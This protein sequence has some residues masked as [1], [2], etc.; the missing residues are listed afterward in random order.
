MKYYNRVFLPGFIF[1][2]L[3]INVF[4]QHVII[5]SNKIRYEND[6]VILVVNDVYRGNIQWEVSKDKSN[7]TTITGQT[8]NTLHLHID[9]SAYYR[10]VIIEGTCDSIYSDTALVAELYDERDNRVYDVV[11]IGMKWWMAENLDYYTDNGTWYYD[12]DSISNYVYGRLYN[13]HVTSG[14]CPEGWHLPK[15]DEWKVLESELGMD[16]FVVDNTGW[17]GTDEGDKLKK[18]GSSGFDVLFGGFRNANGNYEYINSSGTFWTSS[19]A[20]AETAWYRGFGASEANIHRDDFEKNYGFSV[21]CVRNSTPVIE[22]QILTDSITKSSAVI[23]ANVIYDGGDI[24]LLRGL[25]WGTSY[26]PD[27]SDNII[28]AGSGLGVF[29]SKITGLT[30]NNTYYVR[31]F[32]VNSVD[33]AYSENIEFISVGKPILT[34]EAVINITT[35]SAESGGIVTDDGGISIISRGVCWSTLPNPSINDNITVDGSG[36]GS[37]TSSITGLDPNTTYYLKAYAINGM[38]SAYGDERIFIT[39]PVSQIDS[40]IDSRD[41][42]DYKIVKIG[43]QWWFGTNLNYEI[44]NSW[45]YNNNIA[46]C[47]TFGRLYTWDAALNSCPYGWHLP[48]DEEWKILERYLGMDSLDA[49]NINWRGTDQAKQ[50]KEGS[51]IGFNLKLG[52]FREEN[53]DFIYI[54]SSGTFWASEEASAQTAW[55]RGFGLLEENIHRY[56]YD[57][58]I[59]FSI[60]CL[61]TK[62]PEVITD[63]AYNIT[64]TSVIIDA[65]VISDGG[66]NVTERG[67]CY[68][69]STEPTIFD[70]KYTEGSGIGPFTISL[71]GL[72]TNTTYYLRAYAINNTDTAYSNEISFITITKPVV[73]TLLATSITKTSAI[74][75]GNVTDNGGSSIIERGVCYGTN[76]DPSYFDNR[77]LIGIGTG[78]FTS[79]LTGLNSNKTYYLK[80]YAINAKDTAYGNEISFKTLSV[81]PI[82]SMVDYRDSREYSTIK[83]GEQWWMAEN[84]HYSIANS[85]CYENNTIICDTFGRLYTWEAA[86]NS[87]PVEWHLPSDEEWKIMEMELGMT[88][89]SANSEGWRGT[90][91]GTQLKFEGSSGFDV[92]LGGFR[93][94]NGNYEYIYSSGTFWTSS[95]EST[96]TAW[97][98][99]FGAPETNIHRDDFEKNYSFSVRCMKDTLPIVI[100][101]SI[102]SITDSTAISGG[103]ITYDGGASVTARGVCWSTLHDPTIADDTTNNGDDIGTFISALTDLLPNTDYYVRAYA[104]NSSG[105][106]YG[107]EVEFTTEIGIPRLNTSAVTAVTDSSAQSGG[108]ITRAGGATITAKG[109]CWST[110]PAPTIAGD[111]TWNGTGTGSFVSIMKILVP[112]TKYYVRAYATNIEGTGYGGEKEFTTITGKP[113]VITASVST[114]TDSSATCGGNVTYDGGETITARGVC[115][116]TSPVPT[117]ADDTTWNT[118]ELGSFV[119]YMKDLDPNTDYYVCA[120]ATNVNGTSYGTVESFKTITGMPE[121]TTS[122]LSFLNDTSVHSGGNVTYDGGLPVTARGVCWSTLSTPKID[123]DTTWDGNGTGE[124]T[125]QVN[126]L[127]L[128]TNYYLRAYATN[129]NGTAYGG[130]LEFTTSA[131]LPTVT[132]AIP[133]LITDSS[134]TGGGNVT[135]EG[136]TPVTARGVCWSTSAVP[137]ISDDD[138]TNNGQGTG[139]FIS[140]ITGLS[141]LTEYHVRAYATNSAGTDYGDDET[142]ITKFRTDT[143]LDIR[144]SAVY[145]TVMI[146]TKWWMAENLQFYVDS[147]TWYYAND[148]TNNVEYGR[149]YNWNTAMAGADSSSTNPSGVQGICP[150]GWHIPSD[151]EWTDLTTQLGGISVAGGKMKEEGLGHWFPLN[152]GATNESGFTALPAGERLTAGG[153]QNQTSQATFWSTTQ[154]T[155]TDAWCR[156][157]MYNSVVAGR[158][159]YNKT[160]GFSVRCLKD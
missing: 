99:G 16:S 62:P 63:S 11:R 14:L 120:Y 150:S 61:K 23:Q 127:S 138:S 9:S 75:G 86:L 139:S 57:K 17:R 40:I 29:I 160:M 80:A 109:V 82:G 1:F 50:L 151:A 103:E 20:S 134:A 74:V 55:Y 60:R 3:G 59:A 140:A 35:I 56:Y 96:E 136:G 104:T 39:L 33:T 93:N 68:G 24:V 148:S 54:N 52:G 152:T 6:S 4:S 115:W 83:I 159:S 66:E 123:D 7:W 146:G 13:W 141:H 132:T 73:N 149:L 42:K 131:T 142:F 38:D 71:S 97:Y 15:D 117:V 81:Y 155:G 144:D 100:T 114:I 118:G 105:T 76:P 111:T 156:R 107:D 79:N 143:L 77:L 90:D 45:C 153:F 64:K 130:E 25:C 19:E 133:G 91:Q 110:S 58:D 67:V 43:A 65:K 12:S 49:E 119:S 108:T 147:G 32:A 129:V 89:Y 95:E 158:S 113:R 112:D 53:G 88:Q 30:P 41:G 10:A 154:N 26:N 85:W 84:L 37:F 47:D 34:T 5:K 145:N 28:S 106:G 22:A 48:R 87:C 31:A 126:G 72:P 36:M 69:L 70:Y 116:S 122:S 101:S 102:S 157:L 92:L 51:P 18:G 121:V 135:N 78:V 124:F 8:S 21:R 98:R 94:A 46:Y 137:T 27:F 128:G 2:L 125:S 44:A